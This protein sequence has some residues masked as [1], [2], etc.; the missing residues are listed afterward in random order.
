[1]SE[2]C[3]AGGWWRLRWGISSSG[4]SVEDLLSLVE[5]GGVDFVELG[6]GRRE[7]AVALIEALGRRRIETIHQLPF[8]DDSTR[9]FMF[10]PS[11]DPVGSA[12]AADKTTMEAMDLGLTHRVYGVHGGL[13]GPI[14][15]PNDFTVSNSVT[16]EE[17]F[18][19]L[20]G[21]CRSLRFP[22][23]VAV[24]NI[25]GWDAD[26]PALGMTQ[27]ELERMDDVLP[28]V[29][30]LGHAATN[31]VH[32][33]CRSLDELRVDRLNVVEAHV[34]FVDFGSGV[35]WDHRRYRRTDANL[36]IV[37]KLK[38]VLDIHPHVPVVLEVQ[39]PLDGVRETLTYLQSLL[40]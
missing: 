19:N 27:G 28:L 16:L 40:P 37:Q 34:S 14:R 4:H 29:L 13:L 8:Q 5:G 38:E 9:R 20:E 32:Y 1:M 31:L 26:S 25:Y 10:N 24:E 30:D 21:F 7:K 12:R 3:S 36:A 22:A 23:K 2:G 15:G 11:T 18:S 33:L 17:A 39:E 35:P 6:I